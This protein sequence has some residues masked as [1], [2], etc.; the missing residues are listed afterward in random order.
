M[1]DDTVEIS[2]DAIAEALQSGDSL[3]ANTLYTNRLAS[4]EAEESTED[5]PTDEEIA[6]AGI[7]DVLDQ[8]FGEAADQLRAYW[9]DDAQATEGLALGAALVEDH[10]E[11]VQIAEDFGIADSAGVL[12]MAEQIARKSGYSYSPHGAQRAPQQETEPMTEKSG[13]SR[14]GFEKGR[15]DFNERIA[16]AQSEGNH[17]LADEIYGKLLEW[18]GSVK[19]DAPIVGSRNRNA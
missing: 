11:L 5:D 16:K 13:I 10:P 8:E 15:R 2:R 14:E 4:L 17:R 1:T 7:F 6:E 12:L 9:T 18:T 3:L 19:G